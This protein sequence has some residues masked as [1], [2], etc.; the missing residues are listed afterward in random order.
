M[1]SLP[2]TNDG[3]YTLGYEHGK[4]KAAKTPHL[5]SMNCKRYLKTGNCRVVAV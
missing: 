2:V 3:V 1:D 5:A 4:Q